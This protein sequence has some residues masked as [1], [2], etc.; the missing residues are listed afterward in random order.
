MMMILNFPEDADDVV[1]GDLDEKSSE[2]WSHLRSRLQDQ[3]SPLQLPL[4]RFL[5]PAQCSAV[6]LAL[7]SCTWSTRYALAYIGYFFHRSFQFSVQKR[8]AAN[9]IVHS[10]KL[11]QN[12]RAVKKNTLYVVDQVVGIVIKYLVHQVYLGNK[13][14]VADVDAVVH[15]QPDGDDDITGA[16]HVDGDVPGRHEAAQV[17]KAESDCTEDVD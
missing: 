1:L 10:I 9:Q 4:F 17:Y 7:L 3:S 5:T 8:W 16:Y 13:E 11:A 14:G 15:T 2:N 6:S 12:S